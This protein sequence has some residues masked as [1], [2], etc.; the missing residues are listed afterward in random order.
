MGL[1]VSI[2]PRMMLITD[3][4]SVILAFGFCSFLAKPGPHPRHANQC[5][6]GFNNGNGSLFYF[7]E[8][9]R[10]R[11]G[12][13]ILGAKKMREHYDF[14]KMKGRKNPFVKYLGLPQI[15]WVV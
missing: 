11:R 7:G 13:S 1:L 2:E 8:K 12:T 3:V 6:A 10:Q 15:E 14:S 5:R 9:S 4:G